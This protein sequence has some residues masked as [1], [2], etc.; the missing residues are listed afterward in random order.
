MIFR[1]PYNK[2]RI[3][4]LFIVEVIMYNKEDD[5]LV[6]RYKNGDKE[7]FELLY[8]RHRQPVFS[9]ICHMVRNRTASE[10]IFQET[11][12]KVV[13]NIEKYKPCD[14]FRS[15]IIKTANNAAIDYLRRHR[16]RNE[17]DSDMSEENNYIETSSEGDR[18]RPEMI[19]EKKEIGEELV[20]AVQSLP[21]EQRQVFLLREMA[22]LPF[23]EISSMLKCPL[24]TV[25]GRMHYALRNL[26]KKLKTYMKDD[27]TELINCDKDRGGGMIYEL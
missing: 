21:V 17:L 23:K 3:S 12:Y 13:K 11:F 10:D 27:S 25:L 9:F 6:H 22:E 15:F 20:K 19:I 7:A 4:S 2:I 5:A 8:K 14:K 1:G 18:G 16:R 26:R 24:N